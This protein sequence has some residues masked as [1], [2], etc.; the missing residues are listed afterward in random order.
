MT[1]FLD[2]TMAQMK[3]LLGV[4][5]IAAPPVL[6]ANQS[7]AWIIPFSIDTYQA[8]TKKSLS[9]ISGRHCILVKPDAIKGL[10]KRSKET[11]LTF[12]DELVR[13]LIDENGDTIYVDTNGV[14]DYESRSY[15]TTEKNL[16][17]TLES[18]FK[19]NPSL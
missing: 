9:K 11:K 15:V 17:E 8:I 14:F 12:E 1:H 19:C 16:R 3:V 10:L 18:H 4:L 7:R 6:W 2:S 13:S 5:L